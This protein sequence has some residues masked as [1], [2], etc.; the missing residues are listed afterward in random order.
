M[1]R[2]KDNGI[3]TLKVKPII[4]FYL[5]RWVAKIRDGV[6]FD[7]FKLYSSEIIA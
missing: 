5:S 2:D 4:L 3:L 6:S 7:N 1:K